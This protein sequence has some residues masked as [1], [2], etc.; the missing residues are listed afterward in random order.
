MICPN[1]G[2]TNP[3]DA[4]FCI[5]C[6]TRLTPETPVVET[7]PATGPTTR[8]GPELTPAYEMPAPAAAPAPAPASLSMPRTRRHN[9]EASS[10]VFLIGLGLLFLTGH[11]W[12]GILALV[13]VTSF[14]NES[15]RGRQQAAL[16]GLIFFVGLSLLFWSGWFWPGILIVLGLSALINPKW[17][18]GC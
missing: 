5:Y 16:Q 8:L 11:F 6:A 4:H 9:K 3:D 2:R 1:C 18:R 13:G 14:I 15:A 7:A 17:H 10:A 12:P